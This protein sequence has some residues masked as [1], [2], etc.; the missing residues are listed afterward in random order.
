MKR[1]RRLILGPPRDPLDPEMPQ[2]VLLAAMLAWVGFGANGLSSALYGPEKAY[3]A[4]GTHAEFAPL[5]ALATIVTVFIIALA[6]SQVMEIFPSGGGSYKIASNLLGPKFGL[7]SG[8]AQVVDYV[9]TIAVSLA[10]GTDALFS[11]MPVSAQGYKLAAEIGLAV[12]LVVLN[13][14]GMRES[15]RFLAPIVVGFFVVHALLIVFGIGS[16]TGRYVAM[17]GNANTSIR[18]LGAQSGWTFVA[19]IFLRAYGLGGS[20]YSGVESMSNH[21]NLLAEPRLKTGRMAMLYVALSLAFTAGGIMLLYSLESVRPVHGQTLNAVAFSAIIGKLG[22]DSATSQG[23]LLLTLALEGA[24]LLVAANSILIFAPSLLGNMAAD[25]WLP[26]RFRNLSSRLVREDG[27]IFIGACAVAILL[28]TRGELGLLVVFYSINVF[29]CLALSKLGLWRYWWTRRSELRLRVLLIRLSIA[30]AGLTV[31]V[32]VLAIT[33]KEK[34]FE[35]GWATICCTLLVVASCVVVRRHYDWVDRQRHKLDELFEMPVGALSAKKSAPL[36]PTQTTAIFL[37]TEHWGPTIHTLRWVQ[38][39]FPAHFRNIVFVS[40]VQVEASAIAA[41]ET[42]P[43]RKA[44]IERSLDQLE[45]FCARDGLRTARFVAYGIDPVE[46]LEG[47]IKEVRVRF[48]DSVCFSNKLILPA[49][50]WFSEWLHNQTALSLQR[51]LHFA[52]IPLVIFPIKL[53]SLKS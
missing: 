33:L 36:D 16:E 25:S 44:K 35:G 24:I 52:G 30:V 13:L 18:S 41:P 40:A 12:L 42:V 27:V 48:P 17:W 14:R 19:A 5:L 26:H 1:L 50:R 9:L 6:Y 39:L 22:L 37:T 49:D 15:I 23:L 20:T 43:Q 10:S 11:L 4:L 2:R 47:L 53:M 7:V 21:V 34:F 38:R 29:L 31:A 32:L 51:Q 45:A 3:V 8:S 28:W 46:A